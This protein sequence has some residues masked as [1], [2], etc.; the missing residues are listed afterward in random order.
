MKTYLKLVGI[1]DLEQTSQGNN[2]LL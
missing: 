2:H 1:Q